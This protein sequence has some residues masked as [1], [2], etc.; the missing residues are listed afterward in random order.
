[1]L[2]FCGV[3]LF[4]SCLGNF[5]ILYKEKFPN[6]CTSIEKFYN[7][8]FVKNDSF[9]VWSAIMELKYWGKMELSV[10]NFN[11][12]INIDNSVLSDIG[13]SHWFC[14]KPR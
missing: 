12:T 2:K 9:L 8:L 6:F 13:L 14:L 5:L 10:L 4:K 1:M 7:S 11:Y 3:I